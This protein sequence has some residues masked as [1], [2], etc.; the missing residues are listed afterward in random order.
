RVEMMIGEGGNSLALLVLFAERSIPATAFESIKVDLFE[1]NRETYLRIYTNMRPLFPEFH[2][3][4]SDIAN[5]I[6]LEK[7]PPLQAIE[8]RLESWK[9]LLKSISL[10]S[11]ERQLGLLGELWTLRRLISA[12]GSNAVHM[13]TGP[14]KEAH[15]FRFG[16]YELEVKSTRNQR[17][18]H[19][20]STLEQLTVSPDRQLYVL[21]IQFSP[22]TGEATLSLK[23]LVSDIR[24]LLDSDPAQLRKFN[25]LLE[26]GCGYLDSH[27]D[28]YD[29]RF[30][31]RTTPHLIFVD[32]AFPRIQRAH[33]RETL[34]A[35]ENRVLDARYDLDLEGLGVE[36]GSNSFLTVLPSG[37]G[38]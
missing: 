38:N 17:R 30:Q 19:T 37:E 36:D 8:Q 25:T 24:I 27:A 5:A 22:S 13:W 16:V 9:V 18:I 35:L 29:L 7:K 21:S 26:N 31:L 12:N 1:I 3:L 15:D 11:P 34:G 14:I 28:H 23:S 2:T 20:I 10:L 4:I 32:E 33:I 6:Q